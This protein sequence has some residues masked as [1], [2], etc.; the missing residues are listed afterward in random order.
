MR[1]AGLVLLAVCVLAACGKD[2]STRAG[3]P[4]LNGLEQRYASQ[5]RELCIQASRADAAVPVGPGFAARRQGLTR[6][7]DNYER[8]VRGVERLI[9][10]VRLARLHRANLTIFRQ[11]NGA[12]VELRRVLP[13]AG[14]PEIAGA[15]STVA[16]AYGRNDELDAR[17]G[18]VDCIW[19]PRTLAAQD[20]YPRATPGRLAA[21]VADIAAVCVDNASRKV[22]ANSLIA[23]DRKL[24]A[25]A[26]ELRA[27]IAEAAAER[28]SRL[29]A[30]LPRPT[31]GGA[32]YTA[33]TDSLRTVSNLLRLAGDAQGDKATALREQA[34]RAAAA[35]RT[36][37]GR[38]G[39]AACAEGDAAAAT[40]ATT[41]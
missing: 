23:R 20:A 37:A 41:G 3:S 33:W 21:L 1:A 22:W 17:L 18:L 30:G 14:L 4:Q 9:A 38:L 10:P 16:E 35:S 31:D 7:F 26:P 13:S 32:R 6:T 11:M 2:S 27:R 28:L 19:P 8:F 39:L 12:I 29:V 40:S 5:M 34:A 24:D 36:T 15:Y 25:Q